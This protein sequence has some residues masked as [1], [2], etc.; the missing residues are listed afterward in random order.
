MSL[1]FEAHFYLNPYESDLFARTTWFQLF[2][3]VVTLVIYEDKCREVLY[4]DLPDCL[5]TELWILYALDALDIVLSED[6]CRTTDRT[7]VESTVLLT[8]VC[9]ALRTVTLC[10]HDHAASVALEEVNV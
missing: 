8:S 7:E 2:E 6:R 3:K 4:V 5:H 9:H 1:S 10:E